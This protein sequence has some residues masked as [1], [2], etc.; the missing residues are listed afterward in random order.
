M[1][2][3]DWTEVAP[4]IIED[5]AD[6]LMPDRESHK[7]DTRITYGRRGSFVVDIRKGQFFDF[8]NH[9]GG[10]LFD[11]IKH[12]LDL[13]TKEA[14]Y[15]L[16]DNGFLSDDYQ[17][18]HAAQRK[19]LTEHGTGVVIPGL[20]SNDNKYLDY[21]KRLWNESESIPQN[22]NHPVRRWSSHRNLIPS[23]LAFPDCIRFHAKNNYIIV[24]MTTLRQWLASNESDVRAYQVI[25]IDKSGRKRFHFDKGRNDK[26]VFGKMGG[27]G[28]IMLGNPKDPVVNVC[29]GLADGLSIYSRV[30]GMVLIAVTTITKLNKPNILTALSGRNVVIWAD[31]DEAGQGAGIT[32]AN[33]MNRDGI[34]VD[35]VEP[36]KKYKDPA[37]AAQHDPFPDIDLREYRRRVD[38][39]RGKHEP[40]REAFAFMYRTNRE[41]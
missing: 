18:K 33:I 32:L 23:V 11:M 20:Y 39:F 6:E 14:F 25:S 41:V 19:H 21:G 10:G 31:N 9:V 35:Y 13:D 4:K 29:E 36:N 3:I 1:N 27:N 22:R 38:M 34:V 26:R 5:V 30:P 40:E 16:K 8:E 7:D 37:E 17:P 15:W 12:L 28:V 24:C 2:D